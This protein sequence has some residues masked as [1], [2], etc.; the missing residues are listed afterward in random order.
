[1][2]KLNLAFLAVLVLPTALGRTQEHAPTTEQCRADLA[3]WE[4]NTGEIPKLS[5]RE[6]IARERVLAHC[7]DVDAE[8]DRF[9]HILL[10]MHATKEK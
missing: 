7:T 5:F 8:S 9:Y 10:Y 3:V 4:A 2:G 6:L 1:M